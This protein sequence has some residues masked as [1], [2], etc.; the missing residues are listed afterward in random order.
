MK[1]V[2]ITVLKT[3]LDKELAKEYGAD[4]LTAC[5]MLKEG[6]VFYADYAKPEGFAMKHGKQFISMPLHCLTELKK[7]YFTMEIG[8][9]N[10]ALQFAAVTMG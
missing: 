10:Q 4:G 8:L 1:K 7:N 9:E 6:E 2:K 5:P 3:T